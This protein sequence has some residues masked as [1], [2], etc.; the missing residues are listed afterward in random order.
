MSTRLILAGRLIAP[1]EVAAVVDV[2]AAAHRPP[3]ESAEPTVKT[4]R[5]MREGLGCHVPPTH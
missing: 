3:G 1:N 4:P 2:K 5:K